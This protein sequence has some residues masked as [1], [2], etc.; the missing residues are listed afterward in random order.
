MD[1][2]PYLGEL[3]LKQCYHNLNLS[4]QQICISM[5][6][7]DQTKNC[8]SRIQDVKKAETKHY[9]NIDSIRLLQSE[10]IKLRKGSINK[11]SD[12]FDMVMFRPSAELINAG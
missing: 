8:P 1:W 6:H 3:A 5:T 12:L 10:L 4:P 9:F 7:D 11:G 2:M